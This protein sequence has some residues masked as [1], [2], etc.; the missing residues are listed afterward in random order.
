MVEM[1]NFMLYIFYYNKNIPKK[2]NDFKKE[3][4]LGLSGL[5]LFAFPPQI[6]KAL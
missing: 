6:R 2:G 1:V 4:I 3:G 5:N